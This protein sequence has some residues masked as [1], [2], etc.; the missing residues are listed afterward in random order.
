MLGSATFAERMRIHVGAGETLHEV[1]RAQLLAH[2]PALGELFADPARLDKASRDAVI[3]RAHREFGY[4][5][6]E[7]ARATGIHYSTVSRVIKGER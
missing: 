7:I 6:A 2:R 5:L 3:T 1:P 4:S